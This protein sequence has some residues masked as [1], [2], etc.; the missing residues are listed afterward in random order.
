MIDMVYTQTINVYTRKSEFHYK[1]GA[2]KEKNKNFLKKCQTNTMNT[3]LGNSTFSLLFSFSVQL[4]VLFEPLKCCFSHA[5]IKTLNK[6]IKAQ[7]KVNTQREGRRTQDE[8]QSEYPAWQQNNRTRRPKQSSNK[9][10][11][12]RQNHQHGSW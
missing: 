7:R 8:I 11:P 5:I 1:N 9:V 10:W 2:K 3:I 4:K 6:W 12:Y